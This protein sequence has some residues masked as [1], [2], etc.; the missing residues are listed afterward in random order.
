MAI[1]SY[2]MG[3]AS[4][5][6]NRLKA[7]AHNSVERSNR[8]AVGSLR[9]GSLAEYPKPMI[10]LLHAVETIVRQVVEGR[11]YDLGK[12]PRFSYSC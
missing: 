1:A 12:R 8:F 4:V 10:Q 2:P 6:E 3:R 9:I 7:G 5:S 11:D